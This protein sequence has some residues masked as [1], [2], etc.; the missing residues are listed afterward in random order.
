MIALLEAA[1]TAISSGGFGTKGTTLFKMPLP[2][3]PSTATAVYISGGSKAPG[4]PVRRPSFLVLHRNT[5]IQSGTAYVTQLNSFLDGSVNLF[6][7]FA[8]RIES[9][10]L[11]GWTGS[12]DSNKMYLFSLSYVLTTIKTG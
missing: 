10:T 3:S 5:S 9:R 7:N 2:S 1:V 8:G 4:Q 12:L 11:P 6:C